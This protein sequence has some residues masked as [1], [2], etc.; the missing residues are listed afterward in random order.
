MDDNLAHFSF[1][2]DPYLME[3]FV[4]QAQVFSTEPINSF[5]TLLST[6]FQEDY[7]SEGWNLK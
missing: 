7:K 5:R 4:D 3:N 2:L 1:A 6:V